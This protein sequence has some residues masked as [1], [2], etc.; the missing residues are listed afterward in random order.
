[1]TIILTSL[2]IVLIPFVMFP[3]IEFNVPKEILSFGLALSIGLVALYQGYLKKFENRW[4]MFFIGFAFIGIIFAPACREIM[5]C[6]MA[7]GRMD[8]L[9]QRNVSNLWMY[10]SLL[11][12]LVYTLMMVAVSSYEFTRKQMEEMVFLM[13]LCGFLMSL[14]IFVQYFRLDQFFD[15][16]DY[17][18]NHEINVLPAKALGGFLGQP[19]IVAT[20]IAMLVPLALYLRKYIWAICMATAVCLTLSKF[21]IGSMSIGVILYFLFSRRRFYKSV[22]IVLIALGLFL[23]V[24]WINKNHIISVDSLVSKIEAESSGRVT[25]WKT[26]LKDFRSEFEG[27]MRTVL[28]YGAG[29]FEYM[30]SIIRDSKWRTLHNDWGELIFNFGIAGAAIM[31]MAIKY[32]YKKSFMIRNELIIA[33][34]ACLT[35]LFINSSGTFSLQIASNIFYAIIII[36]LLQNKLTEEYYA[37][38]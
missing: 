9:I 13:C 4:V 7:K 35:I 31:F 29:A 21:A 27:S 15:I 14:Y 26:V 22:G 33:L 12:F 19:T 28:G 24:C 11:Y 1:M 37:Q 23:I 32:L 8:L 16:V 25:I 20:Y 36:G 17:S 2:G 10:K 5:M 30:H 3:G 38:G 6:H 34:L 18:K